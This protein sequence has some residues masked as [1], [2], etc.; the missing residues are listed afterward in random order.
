MAFECIHSIQTGSTARKN[1]C[2]YKLDM[3]KAYDRVDWRFLEGVLAKLG[4]HS[5]WIR[6]VMAC[7]TIVRYSVRFNRNMLDSF[8]LSRSI[9]QGDPLFPYLFLF[10]V[11]GLSSFIRKEVEARSICELR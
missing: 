8:T 2:A 7:V 4:F 9:R 1:F 10:V 5:Q 11:D 3:A 6:W